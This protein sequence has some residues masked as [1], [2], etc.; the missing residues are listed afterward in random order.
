M[1]RDKSVVVS[2]FGSACDPFIDSLKNSVKKIYPNILINII[3]KDVPADEDRINKLRDD[4]KFAKIH[5]GSLK[6]ICWNQGMKL[7]NTEWVLFLDNDTALLK[8]I[9]PYLDL[10]EQHKADFIFTWRHVQ[11]QWVNSGVMFVRKNDKT[12]KFFEDYEANMI[13]D[14]KRNQNDQYTFINL[15]NRDSQFV[16]SALSSS[17]DQHFIFDEKNIR[18]LGIHC[19]YLN[20]SAP[21]SDW[22]DETC[23]QHF[24]GVQHTIITKCEKENRY[25]NFIN[26]GI[27]HL[28]NKALK[29]LNHRINLWK[30]FANE[31]Y[32]NDVIDLEEFIKNNK[33]K[34]HYKNV[35]F[36]IKAIFTQTLLGKSVEE[37]KILEDDGII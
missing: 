13:S 32:S 4:I 23:I 10:A 2:S 12:L 1:I 36:F 33:F 27:Y 7:A 3:G 20:R 34:R 31:K 26:R 37:I 25:K 14:I 21:K 35:I 9:D 11:S 24:K 5:P 17:R 28:P 16:S 19:D 8:N 15:L 29:N 22:L 6:I 18:F 30:K